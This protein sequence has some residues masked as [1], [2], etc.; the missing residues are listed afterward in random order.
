MES[1]CENLGFHFLVGYAGTMYYAV[2][3][4]MLHVMVAYINLFALFRGSVNLGYY[5]CRSSVDILRL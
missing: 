4:M 1:F 5:Y 3:E 2:V